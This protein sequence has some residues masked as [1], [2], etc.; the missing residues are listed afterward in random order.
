MLTNNVN[1]DNITSTYKEYFMD[2]CSCL[3]LANIIDSELFKQYMKGHLPTITQYGGKVVFRSIQNTPIWGSENWDA[4][5][6]QEWPDEKTFN[7]WWNSEE[8]QPWAEIRDRA[9]KIS[10][11][12]CQS[13]I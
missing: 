10:I 1:S 13:N 5:A 11:I 8:Y 4:I 9:A 12:R 3:I 7:T 6:L 2:R